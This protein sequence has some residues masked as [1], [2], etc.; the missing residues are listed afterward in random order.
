[1]STIRLPAALLLAATLTGGGASPLLAVEPTF[2][3]QTAAVG[4]ASTFCPGQPGCPGSP[5]NPYDHDE[6]TGGGVAGDFNRDGF[7][8]L[9]V[10]RGN[11][12]DKLYINNGNGTF[13]DHA[14]DWNLTAQ[15]MGKGASVGDY[16]GDGWLDIYVTSAGPMNGPKA[17]CRHKLYRNDGNGTFTDVAVSAGVQCTSPSVEDGFGSA[18]GDYDLDGDLD[19]FVAGFASN[20]T[21]SRI[22]RNDGDGTFT[23]VTEA[24][25][26]FA[27]TPSMFA[28]TPRWV[29]TNEDDYPEMLLEADFDTEH[30][31]RN[32]S[33]GTFTDITALTGKNLEENGMGQTV[34]DFNND[35]KLDSYITSIYWP[36][37]WTGNKLYLNDGDHHYTE[38]SAAAGVHDGGYGWAVLA[39]D[40][41]HDGTTDIL[42]T[43]GD[44]NPASQF[45]NEQSYLWMNNGNNT[46]TEKAIASGLVQLG[47]GRGMSNLDFDNDGDQDVIIY[48]NREPAVFFRNEISGPGTA[49]LRVV[50]DTRSNPAVAPDGMGSRVW[51]TTGATTQI[52]YMASGDNFLS[53]SELTAHF[54]LGL[55]DTVDLLKVHWPDGEEAQIANVEPNRT[56]TLVAHGS[57]APAPAAAEGLLLGKVGA[58]MYFTWTDAAGADD[59]VVLEDSSPEG[60]F[61]LVTGTATSGATGLTLA[62][63]PA[64]PLRFYLVSGRDGG[65]IGP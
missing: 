55:A 50:L 20:N 27:S 29:D 43:N 34:G 5:F 52:R 9:F 14:L 35:G 57:C 18:F 62:Q 46:F 58:G 37:A 31:F 2:S 53:G 38:I 30:Y 61:S 7:Q 59:Y 8:D 63:M 47:E 25:G 44:A 28:F 4:I 33:D 32:N 6:Y 39:V 60:A 16:N 42:E 41:N 45:A 36:V 54:G 56:V 21:G 22:F 12:R 10:L 23:D 3:N 19:L 26:F 1:M 15:H 51:A 49:W 48:A 40:F 24:I 11:G 17:P 65:C 64:A 13:T